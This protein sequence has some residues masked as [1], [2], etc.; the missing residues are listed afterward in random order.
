MRRR[1]IVCLFLAAPMYGQYDI[2][3]ETTQILNWLQ[4]GATYLKNVEQLA[5]AIYTYNEIVRQGQLLRGMQWTN[6]SQDILTVGIIAQNG[7]AIAYSLANLDARFRA[8]YPGYTNPGGT[9]ASQYR[10][11]SQ[12]T[13]DMMQGT[14]RANGV[15]WQQL[16][17]DQNYIHFLQSQAG[18]IT[19]Q[20]QALQFGHQTAVEELNQLAKLRQLMLADV[21]SKQAYQ[22]YE[23]QKDMSRH[24]SEQTFF[25]A[26]KAGRDNV[27]W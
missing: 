7:Q 9:F 11:W 26:G 23:V 5:Q 1:L 4:L 27:G 15:G 10:G 17:S 6:A 12:A 14:A 25:A 3:T 2:A 16:Q 13:M 20:M 18:G 21:Q 19:T 8:A 24:N 22:A